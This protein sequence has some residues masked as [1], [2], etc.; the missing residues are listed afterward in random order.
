MLQVLLCFSYTY[1][2]T[3]SQDSSK[4]FLKCLGLFRRIKY[5][6]CDSI[7]EFFFLWKTKD[8]S[9]VMVVKT[10]EGGFSKGMMGVL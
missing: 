7:S 8:C 6:G 10:H 4:E 3:R 2:C 9:N 1:K 5:L